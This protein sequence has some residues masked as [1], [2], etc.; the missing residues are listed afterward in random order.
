MMHIL[1]KLKPYLERIKDE[2][3]SILCTEYD[4]ELTAI[5]REASLAL[6]LIEKEQGAQNV[7]RK[8]GKS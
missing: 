1:D 3:D 2:A 5:A 8:S 4:R 7:R 6:T